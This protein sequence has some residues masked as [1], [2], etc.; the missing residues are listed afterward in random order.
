M[1]VMSDPNVVRSSKMPSPMERDMPTD[2]EA[3][4]LEQKEASQCFLSGLKGE[5]IK[6]ILYGNS[7]ISF[8]VS[9]YLIY[10]DHLC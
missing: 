5:L 1:R 4:L 9:S 3:K 2:K 6:K 7:V 10:R 8:L